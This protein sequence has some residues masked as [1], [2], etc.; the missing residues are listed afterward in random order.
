M[1]NT[2]TYIIFVHWE[3]RNRWFIHWMQSWRWEGPKKG[4]KQ[5]KNEWIGTPNTFSQLSGSS[6]NY[7]L[8]KLNGHTHTHTQAHMWIKV[9]MLD[10]GCLPAE[11]PG[12][13]KRRYHQQKHKAHTCFMVYIQCMI[14]TVIL[15]LL[16][17]IVIVK[18]FA[19]LQSG[20]GEARATAKRGE[21]KW[22]EVGN[23]HTNLKAL[24][25]TLADYIRQ[26][27]DIL[28]WWLYNQVSLSKNHRF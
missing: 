2:W 6:R 18:V 15:L 4:E 7:K 5:K 11:Q 9:L 28:H 17:V 23:E 13:I 24:N 1:N 25:S 26:Q 21:R 8:N 14:I 10:G 22:K 16:L 20:N 12:P 27:I 19:G 3:P